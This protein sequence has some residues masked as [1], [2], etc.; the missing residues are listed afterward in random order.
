MQLE[1]DS[2]GESAVAGVPPKIWVIS[3]KHAHRHTVARTHC[4]HIIYDSLNYSLSYVAPFFER[5]AQTEQ[6][7]WFV[8]LHQTD[9]GMKKRKKEGRKE[10]NIA[11]HYSCEV[12]ATRVSRHRKR[13]LGTT[14][15]TPLSHAI[16]LPLADVP[17]RVAELSFYVAFTSHTMKQ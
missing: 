14:V 10:S 11:M 13:L 1:R 5:A 6:R 2:V 17:A 16:A 3:D 4:T 7:S 12:T 8:Q 15:C 9:P